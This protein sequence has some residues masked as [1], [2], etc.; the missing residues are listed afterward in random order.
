MNG[1]Q[2]HLALKFLAN[3]SRCQGDGAKATP[4]SKTSQHQI[5]VSGIRAG[6]T[7]HTAVAN[8]DDCCNRKY[9]TSLNAE[10][11]RCVDF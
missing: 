9:T 6:E 2:V 1:F 3:K 10:T 4:L 11:W 7:S 8:S 5:I